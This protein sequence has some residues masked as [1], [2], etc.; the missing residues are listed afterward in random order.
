M[1]SNGKMYLKITLTR[2]GQLIGFKTVLFISLNGV[3][4]ASE[5]SSSVTTVMFFSIGHQLSN[6]GKKRGHGFE[7]R[8]KAKNQKQ[9]YY[10][11]LF[12]N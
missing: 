10:E 11:I 2:C 7:F 1:T 4:S 6:Y 8:D 5:N 3:S 12:L 9:T